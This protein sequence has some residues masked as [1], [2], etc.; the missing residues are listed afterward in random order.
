[1]VED[2]RH[3]LASIALRFRRLARDAV[4]LHLHAAGL[5]G[6]GRQVVDERLERVS[7]GALR[8]GTER[9]DQSL[10]L[11]SQTQLKR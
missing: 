6:E 5:E 9:L 1:M 11:L 2:P 3:V 10:L 4:G 8:E 7:H